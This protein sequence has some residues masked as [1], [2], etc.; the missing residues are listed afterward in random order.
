[1]V[2]ALQFVC[3]AVLFKLHFLHCV[4]FELLFFCVAVFGC[5]AVFLRCSFFVALQLFLRCSFFCVAVFFC[6]A[7]RKIFWMAGCA[8]VEPR[9]CTTSTTTTDTNQVL[10]RGRDAK[11]VKEGS[12]GG[13]EGDVKG[14]IWETTCIKFLAGSARRQVI[15]RR[16]CWGRVG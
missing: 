6:I 10:S 11:S 13:G 5:V 4:F 12:V 8:V 16:K 14:P 7:V 9:P 2:V 3:V 15:Q 1:M